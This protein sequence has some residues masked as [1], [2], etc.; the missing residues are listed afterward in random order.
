MTGKTFARVLAAILGIALITEGCDSTVQDHPNI[1][2][3]IADDLG[4][5]DIGSYGQTKIETPNIDRLAA[6]GLRFTRHYAGSPVCAPS[7]CVLLTGMHTGHS[8]VRGNDEWTERGDVWNYRAMIADSTL[9]GQKPLADTTVTIASILKEQGYLTGAIGKWGLGAPH[10]A[11]SPN[12][13][14]FDLFYGYNCQRMAHTYYPT[15]LWRNGRREWLAN[16]TLPPHTGFDPGADPLDPS[17]Y[18]KFNLADYAPDLMFREVLDFI[19]SCAGKPFFLYW[20]TPIP[21]VALQAPDEWVEKYRTKFGEEEPYTGT[22]GYFPSRYPHATYAAMISYLDNQIGMMISR[23]KE[24]GIYDNTVIIFTSDNGPASTAGTDPD[25][26]GS[27]EPFR[28]SRGF[29]KGSL[30]EG[31]IRVPL[32]VSWPGVTEPG[33]ETDHISAFQDYLPTLAEIGGTVH[34][35]GI[36]GLSFLPVLKGGRQQQQHEYLYWEFPEYGGQQAVLIGNF[37]ALRKAMHSG[38]EIFELY[39]LGKDPRE[40]TDISAGH[41]E[42]MEQ[43]RE[44]IRREHKVSPNPRWRYEQMGE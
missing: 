2:L 29:G 26:F 18:E 6:G 42:I 8:Q 7:R 16:D 32:I 30:N 33:S 44:I 21:H 22:D 41:P 40:T 10:T 38:N 36:D 27:A 20:A 17:S 1:I 11:G 39:D 35:E 23:L 43:V 13:Q 9:E 19:D 34:K 4:Y 24:L 14:G 28:G 3:I 37:K 31:G 12:R 5:A 25:W 15:H